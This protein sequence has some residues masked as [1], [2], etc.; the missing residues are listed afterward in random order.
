MILLKVEILDQI[1]NLCILTYIAVI[2]SL[3]YSILYTFYLIHLSSVKT[4][5]EK[6]KVFLLVGSKWK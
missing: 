3:S 1:K 5:P 6:L 4:S 2:F